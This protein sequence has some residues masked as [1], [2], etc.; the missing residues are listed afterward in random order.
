MQTKG[1]VVL[2]RGWAVLV[3]AK[4]SSSGESVAEVPLVL[5]FNVLLMSFSAVLHKYD[6]FAVL[7]KP[8]AW[9]TMPFEMRDNDEA[10]VKCQCIQRQYRV[11]VFE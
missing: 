8:I 11:F 4:V 10:L 7:S 1:H 5:L 3:K 9:F 2:F 6:H